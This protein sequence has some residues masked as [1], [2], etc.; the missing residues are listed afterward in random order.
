MANSNEIN[1]MAKILAVL[2]NE[3]ELIIK[4]FQSTTA[5]EIGAVECGKIV[6]RV[7]KALF[8]YQIG[9][10]ANTSTLNSIF[11]HRII[12]AIPGTKQIVLEFYHNR[13]PLFCQTCCKQDVQCKTT[14]SDESL[15]VGSVRQGYV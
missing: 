14:V 6:S 1:D 4:P 2:S 15:V 3:E 5:N 10:K 7:N 8:D 13:L 11:T 12:L 9:D